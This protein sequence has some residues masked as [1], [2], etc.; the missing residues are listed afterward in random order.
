[1][2]ILYKNT[3][4]LENFFFPS[5]AKSFIFFIILYLAL[6]EK[7]YF[8]PLSFLHKAFFSPHCLPTDKGLLSDVNHE[9][10]LMYTILNPISGSLGLPCWLNSEE[11]ACNA[12]DLGS[13]PGWERAHGE[14]NGNP[15]QYFCLENLMDREAWQ[16]TVHRGAKC[17]TWLSD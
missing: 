15:L 4:V 17:R 13:I 3:I 8:W 7:R 11:S 2:S 5:K 16:A 10:K 6:T 14:G 1:M 12:G 9:A